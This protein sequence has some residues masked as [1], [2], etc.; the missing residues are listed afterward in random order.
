MLKKR[1]HYE[2]DLDSIKSKYTR[3]AGQSQEDKVIYSNRKLDAIKK[4]VCSFDPKADYAIEMLNITKSFLNG[5]IIANNDI[6]LRVR[7]GEIHAIIG[8]NGAGKSTL[9]SILFGIYTPDSGVIKVNSKQVNFSSAQEASKAGLGMVH[10]HFKLV[11]TN[12]VLQNVILG[13][14]IATKRLGILNNKNAKKKI[15]EIIERYNLKININKKVS[16]LTVGQQQKTEILKLLF[17]NANILIFDEPTAV[18][19]P[20]EIEHFLQMMIDLKK[21]GKTIILITHKFNEIKSIA[22]RAT[23]I[24]NGV[25]ISDFY[26]KNKSIQEMAQE[27][28]GRTLKDVVNTKH[29]YDEK[30]VLSIDKM[31]IRLER[32]KDKHVEPLSFKIHAGE[33]F[34]IAGV[35]GNGQSELVL[36][37]AGLVNKYKG[38]I[39]FLGQNISELSVK[40][41]HKLGMSHVPENRHKHGLI[42]DLPIYLNAVSN[43]INNKTFEHFG[44]MK[45]AEIKEYTRLLLKQYDVRGS[46]RGTSITRGLSGGNQQKLIV[47]RELNNKHS[48]IIMMQPTRGLDLGAVKFIHEKI[49][50]EKQKNN[51]VLLVSYELDE[52]LSLADTIAVMSDG[53]F[54]D[55]G[56]VKK[57]TR[58]YIGELMAG[59]EQ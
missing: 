16:D 15:N 44:F 21:E 19:S 40:K 13:N 26:V 3:L 52:I 23:I 5:K 9:M 56:N 57:M 22:D 31:A 38:S 32:N 12:T 1:K 6:D 4:G 11:S 41:R 25:F 18:L 39:S 50:E 20:D 47:A 43:E 8:E 46:S 2:L 58:Q 55:C 49:L 51:A 28:V 34:A 35:E 36:A 17:T 33:V 42:L 48:L 24:R 14:E 10:Q 7:R 37:I 27:M 53:T 45:N 30:A 29:K 54:K 59:K